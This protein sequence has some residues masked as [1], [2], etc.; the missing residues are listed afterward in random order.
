MKTSTKRNAWGAS[1]VS[2]VTGDVTWN[3]SSVS[4]SITVGYPL[5][6]RTPSPVELRRLCSVRDDVL[7]K[8]ESLVTGHFM[9]ATGS[10]QRLNC[11]QLDHYE[12]KTRFLCSYPDVSCGGLSLQIQGMLRFEAI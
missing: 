9:P 6:R 2:T 11:P 1:F 12:S 3:V 8:D 7:R 4:G 5:V 10:K